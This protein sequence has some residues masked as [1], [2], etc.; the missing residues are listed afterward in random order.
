[1]DWL[2]IE[3]GLPE[4]R[5]RILTFSPS[6]GENDSMRYRVV[7]SQFLDLMTEVTHWLYLTDPGE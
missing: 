4:N 1:M 5:Q 6:Y 7:D 2:R 3:D